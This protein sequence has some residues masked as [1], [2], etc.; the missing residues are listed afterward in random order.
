MQLIFDFHNDA[1]GATFD[2]SREYRYTLWRRW[3]DFDG[4]NSVAFIGLNPSTADEK[5]NDRTVSR[6]IRFARDWGFSGMW[7][8]NLF[9]YRAT[10][11]EDMKRHSSPVGPGNDTAIV[12]VA[13]KVKLVIAA[14]SHHGSH[15]G[16]AD[17]VRKLLDG[18]CELHVFG[19]NKD[20]SPKHPLYLPCDSD[21]YGWSD[22]EKYP[23]TTIGVRSRK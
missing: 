9:A 16:R 7:I 5:T 13:S 4:D 22:L 20:G 2:E 23:V 18:V 6:C 15:L 14:W 21:Y 3:G 17:A 19:L 8:L 10:Y 11:P 1:S 12:E